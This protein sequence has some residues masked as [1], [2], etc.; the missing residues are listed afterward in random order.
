MRLEH[1]RLLS[2]AIPPPSKR[3]NVL[4]F[5]RNISRCPNGDVAIPLATL[6]T[7]PVT[8]LYDP[9]DC[10]YDVNEIHAHSRSLGHRPLIAPHNGRAPYKRM[11]ESLRHYHEF[12]GRRIR[13]GGASKI[14]AHLMFSVLAATVDQLLKIT[15]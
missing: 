6:T 7:Q 3:A 1:D 5:C 13:V 9:M 4:K 12:G 15:G 10:A 14:M 11:Q 8:S 2:R